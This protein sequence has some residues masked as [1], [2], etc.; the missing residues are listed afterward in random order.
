MVALSVGQSGKCPSEGTLMALR[1][2]RALAPSVDFSGASH[3]FWLG[4]KGK[5]KWV[6]VNTEVKA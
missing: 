6:T 2:L 1:R 5:A 4:V 3:V